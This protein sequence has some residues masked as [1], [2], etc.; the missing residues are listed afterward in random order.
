[1][2]TKIKV[3]VKSIK[4]LSLEEVTK[5]K[6]EIQQIEIEK[7]NDVYVVIKI[8]NVNGNISKKIKDETTFETYYKFNYYDEGT[9]GTNVVLIPKERYSEKFEKELLDKYDIG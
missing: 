3:I 1:M 2:E 5:L 6:E 4:R 9:V 8:F 7:F